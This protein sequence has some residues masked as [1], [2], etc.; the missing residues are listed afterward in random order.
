MLQAARKVFRK[1]RVPSCAKWIRT[2]NPEKGDKARKKKRQK[3]RLCP[4][5]HP[6][7]IITHVQ[8]QST[9]RE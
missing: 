9:A 3:K 8:L 1:S 2:R 6:K 4:K 5:E 7:V